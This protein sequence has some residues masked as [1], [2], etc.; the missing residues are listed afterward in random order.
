MTNETYSSAK[1][2]Y[3]SLQIIYYVA[4][5]IKFSLVAPYYFINVFIYKYNIDIRLLQLQK[6]IMTNEYHDYSNRVFKN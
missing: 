6:I 1:M 5:D 2:N 4:I 3:I